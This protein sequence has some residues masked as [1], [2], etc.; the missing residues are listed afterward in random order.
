MKNNSI[1]NLQQ[2]ILLDINN[3]E[4]LHQE[5]NIMNNLTNDETIFSVIK[6]N[7]LLIASVFAIGVGTGA[8]M[9]SIF[10][11]RGV[12]CQQGNVEQCFNGQCP[13]SSWQEKRRLLTRCPS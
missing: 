3:Q 4:K 2:S 1:L 6:Q 13:D 9:F 8:I 10:N 12:I 11:V 5:E 7:K